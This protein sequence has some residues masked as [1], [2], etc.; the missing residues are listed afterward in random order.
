[1]EFDWAHTW[2]GDGGMPVLAEDQ[3]P[4]AAVPGILVF[5][6]LSLSYFIL[7]FCS[8]HPVLGFNELP[9]LFHFVFQGVQ[10]LQ[11]ANILKQGADH[12]WLESQLVGGWRPPV[13]RVCCERVRGWGPSMAL[14][15]APWS[16]LICLCL[17]VHLCIKG[18]SRLL[19]LL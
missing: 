7:V 2:L 8:L 17:W 11:W 19:Q 1:M 5:P 16:T 15:E 9:G 4:G 14:F 13:D 6:G 3:G 18:R 12:L 10:L